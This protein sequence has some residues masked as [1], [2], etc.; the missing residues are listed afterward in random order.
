MRASALPRHARR[1][2]VPQTPRRAGIFNGA[3]LQILVEVYQRQSIAQ[4]LRRIERMEQIDILTLFAQR[5]GDRRIALVHA[6]R[7]FNLN[8]LGDMVTQGLRK[9]LPL[10]SLTDSGTCV[11]NYDA[12]YLSHFFVQ[13]ETSH[14]C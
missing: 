2:A 1:Q 4:V 3:P 5:Q 6:R 7:R 10:R 8:A 12:G 11:A 13:S 9:R 14:A